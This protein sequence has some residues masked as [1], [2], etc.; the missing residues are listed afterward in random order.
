MRPAPCN[1]GRPP[2]L[3]VALLLGL[4]FFRS[5]ALARRDKEPEVPS[6]V[7]QA[8]TL[9]RSDRLEGLAVLEDY[10]AGD[11][12][13]EL[14]P[15]VAVEAG[16][17]RRL[18]DDLSSARAHFQR[19]RACC[20]DSP[21][22]EVATLGLALVDAG[23]HPSGNQI[24]TLGLLA[25]PQAPATMDADRQRLLALAALAEGDHAKARAAAARARVQAQD[26]GDELVLARV[27]H[28][29]AQVPDEAPPPPGAP[30]SA[31]PEELLG[32]TLDRGW[33]LLEDGDLEGAKKAAESFL[34]TFPESVRAREA[35]YLVKRVAAQDRTDTRLVGVLLPL[36][37]TYAPPGLRLKQVIEMANQHAGSPMRLVF[38][39]T[40]GTPE[41][42]VA[43]LEQL[44]L[45][46]GAV[47]V[48]G[49]LLKED[50]SLAAE[51]A[52]ALHVPM[53]SLSQ[54]EGL[55][56]DRPYV[57]RG[58][59]TPV[60]QVRA[61]VAHAMGPLGF[62]KF[63]VLAPET[64][65]G[66][67]TAEAFATEVAERGGAVERQVFYDPSAGDFRKPAAELANKDYK[68]R[69]GEFYRL[70]KA[71]EE[72]GMDPDKVVLPPL[73]D[74]QAI[75]IPDASQRVPLVA[76]ALAYEEFAIGT[77]KPRRDD[78]PLTLLGLNGWHDDQLAV[79]G[80]S[81]VRGSVLVDAFDPDSADP[82][83]RAF[84]DSFQ[85]AV[86][87]RPG[88]VDALGYDAARMVAEAVRTGPTSRA[89]MRRALAQ[90]EL[91]DTVS[92]GRR[93]DDQGEVIR[94]LHILEV[95]AE[96]IEPWHA[97]EEPIP[98]AP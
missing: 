71:A 62:T 11:P 59:L 58:F 73:V 96:R 38:L 82:A 75:F 13:L 29:L 50:A 89:A 98:P 44:V 5:E 15:W 54:T 34:A 20:A 56:G 91:P 19:V 57:F 46:R 43:L 79:T 3:L 77:F 69:A 30:P 17:Q 2:L 31:N 21:L 27:A 55:T 16:E 24:A 90:V 51:A 74:Y 37:G 40:G 94:Q 47:A 81:Y 6:I 23:E 49:P 85:Q 14:L 18:I 76:S 92:G 84:I 33:R 35:E 65:Y 22:A 72:R 52:Q 97:P 68:A 93:F 48:M 78:V 12:A 70:K 1:P 67:L 83:T 9:A 41:H 25:A 42:T 36:T 4:F 45:E 63:A 88:V 10:L 66:R 64:S 95:G 26:S 86:G 61:L 39:D 7:V 28:S 60:Q 80:G 32:R 8:R 87:D 53:V